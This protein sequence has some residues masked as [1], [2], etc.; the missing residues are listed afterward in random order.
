MG[1][2]LFAAKQRA[3]IRSSCG[4]VVTRAFAFRL[5][6]ADSA[7]SRGAALCPTGRFMMCV[8]LMIRYAI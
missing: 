7:N 3:Q 6:A 1:N 5:E 2:D 4:D 8:I